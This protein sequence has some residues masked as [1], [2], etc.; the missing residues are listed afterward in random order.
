MATRKDYT[1]RE[2]Q[3]KEMKKRSI[4]LTDEE[5]ETLNELLDITGMTLRDLIAEM[6]EERYMEEIK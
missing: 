5:N 3:A 1:D 4:R 6:I 2:G